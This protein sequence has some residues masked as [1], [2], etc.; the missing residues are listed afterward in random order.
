MWIA[1]ALLLTGWLAA[2]SPT[3]ELT[4]RRSEAELLHRRVSLAGL[5]QRAAKGGWRPAPAP[6]PAQVY[7]IHI[8]AVECGP[9][10]RELSFFHTLA[11][12]YQRRRGLEL[13]FISESGEELLERFLADPTRREVL[14]SPQMY[15]NAKGVRDGVQISEQPLTLLVDSELIVRQAFVGSLVETGRKNEFVTALER[16]LAEMTRSRGEGDR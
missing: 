3:E 2:L 14:P 15:R 10:V 8:W 6:A 16:L 13:V 7:L 1:D 9:C 5:L 11:Q 12:R 4:L